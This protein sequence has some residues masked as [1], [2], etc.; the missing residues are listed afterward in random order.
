MNTMHELFPLANWTTN[1]TLFFHRE[2]CHM[3][4]IFFSYSDHFEVK[5]YRK[6]RNIRRCQ[7]HNIQ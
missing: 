2:T 1:S 7:N 4:G 6:C 5:I 3:M